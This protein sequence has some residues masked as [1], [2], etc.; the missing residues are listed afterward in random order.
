MKGPIRMIS[1]IE[2]EFWKIEIENQNKRFR[3]KINH[4]DSIEIYTAYMEFDLEILLIAQRTL[5]DLVKESENGKRKSKYDSLELLE[6]LKGQFLVTI[7]LKEYHN[8]DF[9]FINYSSEFQLDL[10][11]HANE[12]FQLHKAI[13]LLVQK[14]S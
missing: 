12:I 14:M 11:G 4:G 6:D 2:D 1:L 10:N 9:K 8:F 3:F 13:N 7:D 5:Q